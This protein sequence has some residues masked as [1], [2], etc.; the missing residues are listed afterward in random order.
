[1]GN[2]EMR[3]KIGFVLL[4]IIIVLGVTIYFGRD[5]EQKEETLFKKE[6]I[7]FWVVSDPHYIDKS[8]T[9]SG[10]AFKK[11]KQTAAGKELDFQKES[12]QA[13]IDKA[14][15]QKPEMLI[16]TGD[17]TLNGEKVS[18]EKLAE[19]LKQ[20]TDKGINVFVIPGN[21]DINDGWARKFVGDQQEKTEVISIADFKKIFA[22][23]GYQNATSYDKSSLSYSVSVNQRYNFLFLDSN[24]YPEDSQ[25]QTSPTTGGTI[26]GKTM[27]W[28]K[29][30]LKKAKEEKKKTV[31][32]LHHNI[33]AH[34]ELLS[35]G[36]VLNNAEEFKKVLAD[37]Q[38]P[39]VFSGHIHAQDIMT[40]TVNDHPLTEI[41]S[42]SFSIAPQGYGVV[43]LNGNSFDYQKQENTHKI[44]Q[45]EN[46]PEYIKELFIE[47]GKRLGYTQ[48]TDAGLSDSKKLDIASE[49][50]GQVNYRFFSGNDFISDEEVEKIKAE[51]GYQIIADNSKFL[52]DYIDS[53]IQDKNQKDNQ[54][55]KNLY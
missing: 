7:E 37:Y 25:P 47:D 24:I 19:L 3:K 30:Q 5:K 23:F 40:E 50:V 18:A 12:W 9:D 51:P 42:S 36:F 29:K 28:V 34:N 39:I 1:M 10:I 55:K 53:I 49:F 38:V 43:T 22:D 52:K 54:L 13:F 15:K 44:P 20:L 41:V 45:V 4:S 6:A 2:D 27:K 31:V 35:N 11:I 32:F 17:L 8:L 26:R 48:L 33:F 16:I 46:Y 21:H 14:I